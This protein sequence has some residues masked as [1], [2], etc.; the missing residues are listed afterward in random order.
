MAGPGTFSKYTINIVFVIYKHKKAIKSH[1][2]P[3]MTL[4]NIGND[5][6]QYLFIITKTNK[7]N[8]N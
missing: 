2:N 1:Q 7:I 6:L 8:K 3:L 4:I 5:D